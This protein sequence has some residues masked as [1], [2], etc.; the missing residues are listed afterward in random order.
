MNS[1][2]RVTGPR[3]KVYFTLGT[4][5]TVALV[6]SMLIFPDVWRVGIYA[7]IGVMLATAAGS[8]TVF[9]GRTYHELA[10]LAIERDKARLESRFIQVAQTH[11]LYDVW[12]EVVTVT[13]GLL[14]SGKP[15][16]TRW[17]VDTEVVDKDNGSIK[18]LSIHGIDP[19]GLQGFA[20]SV[21][22]GAA[23]TERQAAEFDI[24]RQQFN[25]WRD[26]LVTAQMAEWCHPSSAQ[27]GVKLTPSGKIHLRGIANTP[28]PSQ[29]DTE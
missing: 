5:L 3:T 27:Q 14:T 29:D 13:A 26:N 24:S 7:I 11:N 15:Q 17:Q 8:L 1:E 21:V 4:S 22:G 12:G 20:K 28:L 10:M 19:Y 6:L 2:L 16:P 23:F 9:A 25:E 18:R